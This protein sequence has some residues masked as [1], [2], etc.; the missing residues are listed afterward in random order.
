MV[1]SEDAK[2]LRIR[3]VTPER[4]VSLKNLAKTQGYV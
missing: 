2:R 3:E 1:L 4:V